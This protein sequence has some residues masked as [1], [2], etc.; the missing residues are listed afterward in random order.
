[1]EQLPTVARN[2]L[3]LAAPAWLFC[4]STAFFHIIPL[5]FEATTVYGGLSY[6]FGASLAVIALA[7]TL[8]SLLRY[9]RTKTR[10]RMCFWS[11]GM[12]LA[13]GALTLASI[14]I[15]SMTADAHHLTNRCS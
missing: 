15:G 7:L 5:G 6:M 9:G 2:L 13:F 3:V 12:V 8:I 11:I 4:L 1:M 10:L 14:V